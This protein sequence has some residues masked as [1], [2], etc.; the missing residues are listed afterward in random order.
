MRQNWLKSAKTTKFCTWLMVNTLVMK[1]VKIFRYI[2]QSPRPNSKHFQ[3]IWGSKLIFVLNLIKSIDMRKNVSAD[4][5][6]RKGP[7][8]WATT[9][10]P[11]FFHLKWIGNRCGKKFFLFVIVSQVKPVQTFCANLDSK[12]EFVI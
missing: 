5:C 8:F 3:T 12:S 1:T 11:K 7:L 9:P 4:R 2:V 6:L 10:T